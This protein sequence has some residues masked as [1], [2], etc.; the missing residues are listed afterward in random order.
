MNRTLSS[1]ALALA[2]AATPSAADAARGTD[3]CRAYIDTL[4]AVVSTPGVYCLRAGLATATSTG[5]A[6]TV[7][8]HHITI[9]CNDFRLRGTAAT[10][11]RA[12]GIAAD[13]K[14]N[15]IVRNCHID[16]FG[17]GIVLTGNGHEVYGNRLERITTEGISV[18][19]SPG[20]IR[21][22]RLSDIGVDGMR[23]VPRAIVATGDVDIL[24]NVIYR[25][26]GQHDTSPT[27]AILSKSGQSNVIAGNE[28]MRVGNTLSGG[29]VGIRTTGSA[30]SRTVIRDNLVSA[31]SGNATGYGIWCGSAKAIARGNQVAGWDSALLKCVSSGNVSTP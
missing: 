25:V 30:A 8:G 9:D 7:A 11:T 18:A 27:I 2:A 23:P 22:N 4:P 17:S 31:S 24:R 16:G 13:N 29:A 12:I 10:S 15:T 28:V 3:S 6:I 14:A 5:T 20:S 19:S 21:D 26:Q 1:C